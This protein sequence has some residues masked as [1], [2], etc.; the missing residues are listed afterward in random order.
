[1]VKAEVDW[2]GGGVCRI[3]VA[4][5]AHRVPHRAFTQALQSTKFC[6]WKKHLILLVEELH[7]VA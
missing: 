3:R 4:T 6:Y 7:L 2:L 1:M 5:A